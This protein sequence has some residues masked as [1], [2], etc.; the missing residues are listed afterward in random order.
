MHGTLESPGKS[1]SG[2]DW[3]HYPGVRHFMPGVG[4]WLDNAAPVKI[5]SPSKKSGPASNSAGEQ[6]LVSL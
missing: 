6:R 4:N 5:P 3:K 1:R 2:G